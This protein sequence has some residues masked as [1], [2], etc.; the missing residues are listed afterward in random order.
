MLKEGV[1]VLA[2]PK[3]TLKKGKPIKV[4]F[5]EKK[6]NSINAENFGTLPEETHYCSKKNPDCKS[7]IPSSSDLIFALNRPKP[8]SGCI[9]ADH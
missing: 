9:T 6:K 7:N 3:K 2:K 5:H 4:Y 8:S 1:R